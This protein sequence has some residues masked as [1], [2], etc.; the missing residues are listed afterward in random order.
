MKRNSTFKR[1]SLILILLVLLLAMSGVLFYLIVQK[2]GF[3]GKNHSF[4]GPED[5]KNTSSSAQTDP[6]NSSGNASEEE[7]LEQKIQELISSMT[8]EEKVCQLFF[9]TPEG[10]T[11]VDLATQAGETTKASLEQYPVGGIIYF[12]QNIENEKQLTAMTANMQS[13]S[14]LPLFIGIDE[15]GG[16]LVARIANN[17]AFQVETF[18]NMAEIGATG[19]TS[20]A[21]EVGNSIGSYLKKYGFNLDF[22]PDADVLTNPENTAIGERSFGSDPNL[23]AQMVAEEVKGF[24][25]QN[26]IPV[27]KHFPGHGGTAEDSHHG[28]A[29]LNRSLEELENAEFL[30][31]KAGIEAGANVVMVGHLQVPQLIS[32]DTPASLSSELITG[33]LREKLGFDGIVITDSLSMGA[34]TEY[35]TPDEAA[36]RCIQAGGD[37]LLMPQDFKTAYESVLNAVKNQTIPESRIDE[38]LSRIFHVKYEYLF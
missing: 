2:G 27:L 14:Q 22:A 5:E 11:G 23:T 35:Y 12:S 15:E 28:A 26:V 1:R 3:M 10:L 37:M 18:P 4:S 13:Y 31:F 8:L 21:F 9:V 25:Q 20:K 24:Q 16:S 34:I 32:D 7:A 36:V 19:D 30:P 6:A 17:P 33:I 29:V 38:S